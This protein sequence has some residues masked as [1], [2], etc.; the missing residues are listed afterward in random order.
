MK[1]NARRLKGMGQRLD[2]TPYFLLKIF[3]Y[4]V[5]K[6]EGGWSVNLTDSTRR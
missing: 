2:L 4:W 5:G 1:D 3:I 6:R